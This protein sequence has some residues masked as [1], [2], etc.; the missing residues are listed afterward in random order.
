MGTGSVS[1]KRVH[2]VCESDHEEP[3]KITLENVNIEIEEQRRE[4]STNQFGVPAVMS[5]GPAHVKVSGY[6][7]G[8]ET[9]LSAPIK[10]RPPIPPDEPKPELPTE[11]PLERPTVFGSF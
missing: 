2:L 1:F 10:K 7:A 4:F 9:A 6:M 5:V 3:V 11:P 8:V